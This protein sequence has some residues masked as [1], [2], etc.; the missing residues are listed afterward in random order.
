MQF[1]WCT[2]W[3]IPVVALAAGSLFGAAPQSEM[4]FP[5]IVAGGGVVM[6]I[7]LTNSSNQ[8]ES[9]TMSFFDDSGVP[10]TLE[11]EGTEASQFQFTLSAGGALHWIT[12]A[13]GPLRSGYARIATADGSSR[14]S[15]SIIFRLGGSE[16]SIPN[17]EPATAQHS[18]AE[19]SDTEDTGA[20]FANLNDVPIELEL[21]LLDSTGRQSASRTIT[22]E[23]GEKQAVF[24][25]Q[26]FEGLAPGFEGTLHARSDQTFAM[27]GLRQKEDG[28]LATLAG[29]RNAFQASI[30][31]SELIF[32]LDTGIDL[33]TGEFSQQ[34]LDEM[35]VFQL[36]G[37]QTA[38][39]SSRIR[40]RNPRSGEAVTV[41]LHLLN[42]QC[43]EVLDY[44]VVIPCQQE[45]VFDPFDVEIPGTT[46]ST[47]NLLFGSDGGTVD[48]LSSFPISGAAFGSGHFLLIATA[49]GVSLNG[50]NSPD[51]R[52][53]NGI[54]P[55]G[56]CDITP[57]NTGSQPALSE[58]NVSICNARPMSFDDLTGVQLDGSD[59]GCVGP[60]VSADAALRQASGFTRTLT[61]PEGSPLECHVLPQPTSCGLLTAIEDLGRAE[62]GSGSAGATV[63]VSFGEPLFTLLP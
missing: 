1:R 19:F 16:V 25:S 36:T 55:V 59:D 24:I 47:P 4:T 14:L 6:E 20:A 3:L 52:F 32:A 54:S 17:I 30:S 12:D 8:T 28:T 21:S 63:V 2:R 18:F 50:D 57:L 7:L 42:D 43:R 10:L 38:R 62:C 27:L 51:L 44:L 37:D 33:T 11:I 39:Q 23:P 46:F 60:V 34:E 26:L 58:F 49:V 53:P 35:T 15:G 56:T 29:S 13:D 31:G 5:H 48:E 40:L 22:L 9:G 45:L 41:H 61:V